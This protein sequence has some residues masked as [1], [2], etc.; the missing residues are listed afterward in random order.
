VC[1]SPGWAEHRVPDART[2]NAILA[3]ALR[4]LRPGGVLIASDSLASTKLHDFHVGDAYCPV[5]PASL[6]T[7]LQ[8]I[9]FAQVNVFVGHWWSAQ[10]WKTLDGS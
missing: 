8:T 3:E 10:A 6:I 7:R 2:Q 4:V 5:D 9:G 1:P